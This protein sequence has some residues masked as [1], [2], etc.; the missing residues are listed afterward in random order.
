MGLS[1]TFVSGPRR[2][3]KSAVIHTMIDRLW[4]R[5]PHYIR[6]VKNGGDKHP[7]KASDRPR[8]DCGV[9]SARW[10]EYGAEHVFEILSD[11]LTAIH[12]EDR[13]GSVAVEADADPVLRHAYPYDHRVLVMPLPPSVRDVFRDPGRAAIEFQRVLDDTQAFAAEFFGLDAGDSDD[14]EPREARPELSTAQMRSFLYSPLGDELASRIQLQQP[15]HGLV[16]S[17]VI[18]INTGVG[19]RTAETAECL[20]RVGRL[21]QRVR[22]QSGRPCQIFRCNPCDCSSPTGQRLLKALE[23]MCVGGK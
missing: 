4:T 1:V 16:E 2:S 19:K 10:V 11:V 15:Y 9:A 14:G 8:S 22:G 17:D 21:L 20:R 5:P 12:C 6:L 7:P 13:F 23:P 18:I 3:G